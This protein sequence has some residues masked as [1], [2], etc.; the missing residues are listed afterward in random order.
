MDSI[1]KKFRLRFVQG[2][3]TIFLGI[4]YTKYPIQ[5]E[6]ACGA[7]VY[8]M[9]RCTGLEPIMEVQ[10]A[11]GRSD[12]EVDAGDNHLVL[13]FKFAS[14]NASAE[15]LCKAGIKQVK[16]RKYGEQF[17]GKQLRRLVLVFSQEAKQFIRWSEVC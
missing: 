16:D 3:N 9:L 11:L 10:N 15:R 14:E 13:E 5:N 8:L 2:L 7:A 6:A 1:K 12:L 4:E 17:K